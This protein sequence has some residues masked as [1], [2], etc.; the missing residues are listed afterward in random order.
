MSAPTVNYSDVLTPSIRIRRLRPDE[1][2]C[3]DIAL[4]VDLV[5]APAGLG[6]A[7]QWLKAGPFVFRRAILGLTHF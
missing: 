2:Q 1:W 6:N 3:G 5:G 7:V 4:I